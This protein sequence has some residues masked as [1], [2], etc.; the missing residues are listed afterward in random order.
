MLHG[1]RP[2]PG[3]YWP[4]HPAPRPPG[5]VR[6]ATWGGRVNRSHCHAIGL[7]LLLAVTPAAA[8]E[9]GESTAPPGA[10]PGALAPATGDDTYRIGVEDILAISVWRDVD[11]TREVPVRPEGRISM[12]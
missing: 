3:L 12:R 2:A 1:C 8:Q 6:G 4:R 9:R 11:L 5:G 7:A 10:A